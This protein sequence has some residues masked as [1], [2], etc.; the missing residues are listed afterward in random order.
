VS[1]SHA[2]GTWC[3][4][5]FLTLILALVA[6]ASSADVSVPNPTV[7]GPIPVSVP[8]GDP[9]HDYPQLAT[10]ADLAGNGY[11]E[12]EYFFSGVANRYN[13]P[14]LQTG[15]IISSG[16]PYTSRMIVRRPTDP[17]KFNGVV[18]VE[19]VN[20]TPGY[21]FDLLWQASADFFIREGY[22][23]VGVSAQRAG[24]HQ[25]GVG[26]KAWSPTRYATL[27]VTVNGTIN[28]DSMSYDIFAQGARAVQNPHGVDP[29]G[30]LPSP[31]LVIASGVSQSQGRLVTYYN[32]VQ[33]LHNLFD[34][35]YLHLGV[36]G[37]LRTDLPVKV[38]KINT[39]NDVLGLGEGVARQDDSATLHT[40]EIAGASHVN[41]WENLV[42]LP[43]VIRDSLPLPNTNCDLP[44]LS[45]IQTAYVL[46]AAY[47]HLVR[48]TQGGAAPPPADRIQLASVGNPSIAVRDAYGNALGGIR[49]A[50]HAVPTATN[51]GV[52]SGSSFCALYGTH[53]PFSAQ[54]LAQLY[55]NHGA[56]VSA[57]AHVTNDNVAAGYLLSQ[58][59]EET[60]TDAGES[61]FGKH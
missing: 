48:W 31:R 20:V 37:R 14:T 6:G 39:E 22:A 53:I 55:R 38:F 60:M 58:D 4:L 33:P 7:I 17:A 5:T 8:L 52:N 47:G 1:G 13:T 43:L 21:N 34:S 32:S 36:G 16:N 9:S 26:L 29:L 59:A 24:I 42:R 49:L 18:V 10:Q 12:E 46:N 27:D 28:N 40:W 51:T 25:A 45:H 30:N 11:V 61:D 41:Y 54:L 23:Y 15:T 44:S 19:W 57:V 35:F 50:E 2:L 3:S 56:Y